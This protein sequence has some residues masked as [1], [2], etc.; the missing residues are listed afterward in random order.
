MSYRNNFVGAVL[1]QADATLAMKTN[2]PDMIGIPKLGKIS[3]KEKPIT[4]EI[5]R[6]K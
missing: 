2:R 6:S 4:L 1:T 3:S 5:I